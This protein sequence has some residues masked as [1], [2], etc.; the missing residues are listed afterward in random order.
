MNR[1][2][3]RG[4]LVGTLSAREDFH[5]YYGSRE[6]FDSVSMQAKLLRKTS[7]GFRFS[8]TVVERNHGKEVVHFKTE[9]FVPWGLRKTIRSIPG[10]AVQVFY[11]PIP[12]SE[13]DPFKV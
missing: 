6:G 12:A 8:W 4:R 10:Y 13:L 9:E 11:S 7:T 3:P 1:L 2:P 5:F